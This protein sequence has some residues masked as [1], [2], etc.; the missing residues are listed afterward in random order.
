MTT[1][2]VAPWPVGEEDMLPEDM[3]DMFEDDVAPADEAAL[4]PPHAAVPRTR[5]TAAGTSSRLRLPEARRAPVVEVIVMSCPFGWC[6]DRGHRNGAG[7]RR[8][9]RSTVTRHR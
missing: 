4:D 6:T 5:A 1:D 9:G 3:D 2:S 7:R 8:A